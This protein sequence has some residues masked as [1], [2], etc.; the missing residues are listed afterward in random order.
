MIETENQRMIAEFVVK[1]I[2]DLA[3]SMTEDVNQL[4]KRISDFFVRCRDNNASKRLSSPEEWKLDYIY[5]KLLHISQSGARLCTRCDTA[6]LKKTDVMISEEAA[7]KFLDVLACFYG[8]FPSVRLP[9][10]STTD[11]RSRGQTFSNKVA[12]R[13]HL[14]DELMTAVVDDVQICL[15]ENPINANDDYCDDELETICTA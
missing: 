14:I 11:D 1:F 6:K 10:A 7:P 5:R 9:P 2:S 4:L 8:C 13:L 15:L 12:D 3:E